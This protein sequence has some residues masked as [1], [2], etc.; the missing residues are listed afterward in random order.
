MI[1]TDK[2]VFYILWYTDRYFESPAC[3]NE[4]GAIWAMKKKYQEILMPNFD[5]N[6]IYGLLDKQS[7]HFT[8]RQNPMTDKD[9]EEF[10]LCYNP[11]NRYERK[12]TYSEQNPEGRWR[13]FSADEILKRDKTSLDIFWLKDKSFADLDNL[14][15]PDELADD[16]IENLESA[17]E[18]FKELKR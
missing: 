17:L 10:I 5:A 4:V 14:P 9:L 1:N 13:R 2:H 8:L 3:L 16:I 11:K 12:E 15:N 7:M 18:S 6:K